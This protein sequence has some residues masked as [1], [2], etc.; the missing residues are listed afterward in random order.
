MTF[1]QLA[2]ELD[3]QLSK[4]GLTPALSGLIYA[5]RISAVAIVYPV[6]A[7]CDPDGSAFCNKGVPFPV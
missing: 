7:K 1:A 4:Q 3:G 5:G 2:W 6:P